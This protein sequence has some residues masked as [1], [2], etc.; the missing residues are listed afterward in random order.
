MK[1]FF[2]RD[3][4]KR[5]PSAVGVLRALDPAYSGTPTDHVSQYDSSTKDGM[6]DWES[7]GE[8]RERDGE[9][10][11]DRDRGG[12]EDNGQA[13]LTRMIGVAILLSALS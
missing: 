1:K 9:R 13:E 4:P 10:E 5:V 3:K 7:S 2:G 8:R 6:R 12:Q 11:R